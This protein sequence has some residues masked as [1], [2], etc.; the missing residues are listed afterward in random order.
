ML[1]LNHRKI[2]LLMHLCLTFE[3]SFKTKPV[4][5]HSCARMGPKAICAVA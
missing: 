3:E 1:M 5:P 4:F 2:L